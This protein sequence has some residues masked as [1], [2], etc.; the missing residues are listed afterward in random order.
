M[1]ISNNS[2][3]LIFALFLLSFVYIVTVGLIVQIQT[4]YIKLIK[5]KDREIKK[6]NKFIIENSYK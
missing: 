6:L 3:I 1:T 5:S 4:E 2:K